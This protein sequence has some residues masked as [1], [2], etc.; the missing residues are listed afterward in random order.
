M[1]SIDLDAMNPSVV[2]QRYWQ[3]VGQFMITVILMVGA[4]N[5]DGQLLFL[6]LI[7]A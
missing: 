5:S 7:P 1:A 3:F 6:L 2:G 4:Y